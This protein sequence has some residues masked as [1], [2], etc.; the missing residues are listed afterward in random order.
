MMDPK[1]IREH[2]QWMSVFLPIAGLFLLFLASKEIV[3]IYIS[4]VVIAGVLIVLGVF[5]FAWRGYR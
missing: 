2:A 1:N 4:D 3:N 5:V